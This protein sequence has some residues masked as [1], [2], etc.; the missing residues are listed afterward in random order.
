MF[1]GTKGRIEHQIEE[2]IY[3][4]GTDTEQGGIKHGGTLI[5]I[6][7]LRGEA[8]TVEPWKGGKGG[9]GGGDGIMLDDLLGLNPKKDKFKR[10]AD[11]R[12]GA[13]SVL[14]GAAANLSMTTGKPV[15]IS[16][17]IKNL[18]YPK[19]TPMPEHEASL[20]MPEI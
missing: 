12:S 2:K 13:Y 9:H 15:K 11:H 5:R 14:T 1:N 19:Y 18:N 16:E 17:L 3:I 20:E 8:Y 4:S 10:L 6:I 7:P